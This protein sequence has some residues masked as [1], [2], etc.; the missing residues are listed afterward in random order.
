MAGPHRRGRPLLTWWRPELV[1]GGGLLV[2]GAKWIQSR[3]LGK[4]VEI[5]PRLNGQTGPWNDDRKLFPRQQE[6]AKKRWKGYVVG[7]RGW[8]QNEGS[9][10]YIYCVSHHWHFSLNFLSIQK[11]L[12]LNMISSRLSLKKNGS[13]GQSFSFLLWNTFVCVFVVFPWIIWNQNTQQKKRGRHDADSRF[14]W[15]RNSRFFESS[16]Y[17][18]KKKKRG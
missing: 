4:F 3:S 2:N 11:G 17:F 9:T 15:D 5:A 1:L 13:F 16:V 10:V 14:K 8:A 6:N 18:F 12:F 7:K